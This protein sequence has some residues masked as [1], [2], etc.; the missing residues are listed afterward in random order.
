MTWPSRVTRELLRKLKRLR[1]VQA[2]SAGVDALDFP[3]L[4]GG[5]KV[6]SNAAAYSD[7]V[8]ERAWGRL[9]D[10]AKGM[11]VRKKR[12]VP[13]ELRGKT[14]LVVGCGAIGSEVA[15]LSGSL[16]MKTIGVSRSFRFPERFG[17]KH[18][19]RELPEAMGRADTMVI[20]LPLTRETRGVIGYG[21]LMK[22]NHHVRVVNVGRGDRRGGGAGQMVA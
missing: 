21:M 18:D 2:M 8:A 13:R 7:S 4:P 16:E 6:F 22:A 17:E 1:M 14:L 12:V 5:V 15:R 20:A 10:L 3:S 9:L 11:H 19:L